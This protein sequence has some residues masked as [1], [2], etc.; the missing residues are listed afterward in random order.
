MKHLRSVPF[1]V[2]GLLAMSACPGG[3]ESRVCKQYFEETERCAAK[4]DPERAELLRSMSKLAHD[5]F[6]K[7]PNKDGVEESCAE[8]LATLKADPA[9]K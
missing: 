7:Q 3:V 4:T 5:G 1:L 8:M 9:C 6:K 2:V